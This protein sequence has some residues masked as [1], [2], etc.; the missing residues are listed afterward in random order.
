MTVRDC[1]M[2]RVTIEVPDDLS[3]LITQAGDRPPELLAHSLR[4][5]TLPTQIYRHMLDFLA[6][7]PTPE[8]VAA[9]GPTQEMTDRLRSLI[10]REG[11][12]EITPAER[13]EL[14]EYERLEHLMVMIKSGSLRHLTGARAA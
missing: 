4:E 9:F 14:D 2:A 10:E 13:A 7:R 5:P 1:V 8:Q 3:E 11:K 12:G 6:G